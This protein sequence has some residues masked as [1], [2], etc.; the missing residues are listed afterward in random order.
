MNSTD[1]L[2]NPIF[3]LLIFDF[4]IMLISSTASLKYNSG[5]SQTEPDV[6]SMFKMLHSES[7]QRCLFVGMN[8]DRISSLSIFQ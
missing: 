1:Y 6:Y 3:L 5:K 4:Y 8:D 2:L 7:L